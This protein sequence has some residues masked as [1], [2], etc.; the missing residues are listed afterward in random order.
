VTRSFY[1]ND[2]AGVA[3]VL[4]TGI[5][6]PIITQG[7]ITIKIDTRKGDEAIRFCIGGWK[8]AEHLNLTEMGKR[9]GIA[10]QTAA[11]RIKNPGTMTVSELRAVIIHAGCSKDDIFKM[12]T[13]GKSR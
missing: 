13:G 12:I 9:M 11:E 8:V 5:S 4:Q 1:Q 2:R 3:S 7:V 6:L 10:R